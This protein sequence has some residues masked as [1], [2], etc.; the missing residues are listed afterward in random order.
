LP[1]WTQPQRREYT[2]RCATL[3]ASLLPADVAE[4]S[5]STLPL[6]FKGFDHS[7]DLGERSVVQLLGVAEFLDSLR[8]RTGK[9]IRLG[10]EPEPL[11]VLETTGETLRF[12][13]LVYLAA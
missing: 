4:G 11:C 1:D 10:I 9:T 2:E 12:F 3:L 13:E 8:E 7:N 5:I 6:G